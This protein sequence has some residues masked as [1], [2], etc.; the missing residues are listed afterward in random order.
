MLTTTSIYQS[1]NRLAKMNDSLKTRFDICMRKILIEPG[2]SKTS[3][4]HIPGLQKGIQSRMP[5][6]G[7]HQISTKRSWADRTVQVLLFFF[8]SLSCSLW[9]E[10]KKTLACP[11]LL[12]KRTTHGPAVN[13]VR[14]QLARGRAM[15]PVRKKRLPPK[16]AK[17][18]CFLFQ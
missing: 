3:Q 4:P 7:N 8:P 9:K 16:D 2:N 11:I 1:E 10:G 13:Y 15:E 12:E 17:T 18:V 14:M 5:W 6:C